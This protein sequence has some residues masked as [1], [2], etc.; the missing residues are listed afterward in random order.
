MPGLPAHLGNELNDVQLL[1][2]WPNWIEHIKPIISLLNGCSLFCFQCG[3]ILGQPDK[4]VTL[5]STQIPFEVFMDY[6][7]ELA[8]TT[9]R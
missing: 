3:T 2:L 9:F 6:L 4:K 8:S 5:G 1:Q 7:Q